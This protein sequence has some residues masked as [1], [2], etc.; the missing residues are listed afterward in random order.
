MMEEKTMSNRNLKRFGVLLVFSLLLLGLAAQCAAPATPQVV[1]K[2]V[3][4]EVEKEVEVEKVVTVEVE[5]EVEVE[6]VV[7]VEV[8]KEVEVPVGELNSPDRAVQEAKQYAGTT[9][10]VVWEAGLQSQDPLTMGPIWEELTGIKINVVELSYNDIYS[11]QLQD[12]LTGGSSYDVITFSPIWLIDYVNAGVVEPL[13][14]YIEKYMNPADL[15]D[16]LPVYSAEGYARMGD[17][18]YGLPDDG[19]VF[20]LYYRKDLF[21]DPDNMA[22]FKAEYGYDLAPPETWQ[23]FDE[24]GNFFTNKYAPDLYGGGIQRLEGQVYSWWYGAFSGNDGQFFDPDSMEPKVNSDVGV[25][26]LQQMVDQNKWMP[27]GVEKWDFVAI[28]S[29]WMDGKLA[30]VITW[31]PI[32]RWSAGYG[33][34]TEQLSWVPSSKVAGKVGYAPMPGGRP[35]LAGGFSL[36]VSADSQNK[37]AAYL[38]IQWM[39]SPQISLQRVMLPYALRDPF[40]L[41][42]FESPLYAAQWADAPEYL[43]TLQEAAMMGQFELGIPGAREYAEAIDNACTSAFAGTDPKEAMDAAAERWSDITNR[44]GAE[45]QKMNYGVWLEGPWNRPGPE[46]SAP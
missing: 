21:E 33:A 38:F 43:A 36:G 20:I 13:N 45:E 42:H 46:V 24:I 39:N 40:R 44:L 27:P 5:K 34:A 18:W 7:T 23:Q 9:L 22:E 8:E 1:E 2:V 17:T 25:L 37:E 19:D 12:H 31:P 10:N 26:T 4:V 15:E 3:T 41:S 11:N 30:M 29:A 28:L 35:T 14:P 16:F 6:K 32:G